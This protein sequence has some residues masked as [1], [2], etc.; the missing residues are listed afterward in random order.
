MPRAGQL[1]RSRHGCHHKSEPAGL[2]CTA[3]SGTDSQS[4]NV[5]PRPMQTPQTERRILRSRPLKIWIVGKPV[6][7]CDCLSRKMLSRF[8]RNTSGF[9]WA[10]N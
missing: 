1:L 3:F 5:Y 8:Y 2:Q 10:I 6:D 4:D 7:S 9:D